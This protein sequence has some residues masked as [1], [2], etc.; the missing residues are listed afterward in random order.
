MA[1]GLV[2]AVAHAGFRTQLAVDPSPSAMIEAL[3]RILCAT[4]GTR[5]FFTCVYALFEGNGR[6]TITVCGHPSPL[7]I[8]GA[9]KVVQRF[10]TGSYPLGIRANLSWDAASGSLAPGE[11]L[12]LY[13][14]GLYETCDASDNQFGEER[15]ERAVR[16]FA[17]AR[18][19]DLTRELS[20]Q[21]AA[22]CGRRSPEDDV[23][24]AAI[25][26]RV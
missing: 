26:K 12:L 2:M 11:T 15:I 25:R 1:A 6:F 23:S 7:R 3:N 5:S 18:P 16:L 4:G 22:F 14:D 21:L 24:I 10:G 20:E 13:S 9:G 8:D 17:G 19:A